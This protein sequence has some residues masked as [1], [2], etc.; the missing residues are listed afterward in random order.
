MKTCA[1]PL[2][3]TYE[4]QQPP[5]QQSNRSSSNDHVV[6]SAGRDTPQMRTAVKLNGALIEG[7][8][9]DFGTSLSLVT[10]TFLEL[11][12]RPSVEQFLHRP[13]TLSALATRPFVFWSTST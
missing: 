3:L 7:A 2:P 10:T 13:Q 4:Q 12:E 8:L 6:K 11:P 1:N 9:V 5:S